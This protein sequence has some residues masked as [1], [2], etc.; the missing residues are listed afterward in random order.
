MYVPKDLNMLTLYFFIYTS[1]VSMRANHV[2][3]EHKDNP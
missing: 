2:L 1:T 3:D